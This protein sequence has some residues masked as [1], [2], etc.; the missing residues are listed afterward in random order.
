MVL[1]I[2]NKTVTAR[3]EMRKRSKVTKEIASPTKVEFAMTNSKKILEKIN[4]FIR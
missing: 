2:R 3:S 1:S 4:D